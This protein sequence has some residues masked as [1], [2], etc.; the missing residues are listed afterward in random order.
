MLAVAAVSAELR[1]ILLNKICKIF[2]FLRCFVNSAYNGQ[3]Y[4]WWP[5][6]CKILRVQNRRILTSLLTSIALT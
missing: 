2:Q 4:A 6:L 3:F 5:I 1:A